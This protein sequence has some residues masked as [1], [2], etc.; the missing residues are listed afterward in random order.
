[1]KL[2]SK[3]LMMEV[4]K[5]LAGSAVATKSLERFWPFG[6]KTIIESMQKRPRDGFRLSTFS[7]G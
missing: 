7:A 6:R 3:P 5:L 1:M 4:E 2:I